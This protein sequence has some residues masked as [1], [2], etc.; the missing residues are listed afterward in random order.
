MKLDEIKK[1]EELYL[2]KSYSFKS[3]Q[4]EIQIIEGFGKEIQWSLLSDKEKLE[5]RK[6]DLMKKYVFKELYSDSIILYEEAIIELVK[7]IM[8][9]LDDVSLIVFD[10]ENMSEEEFILFRLKNMLYIELYSINKRSKLQFSG[11]VLFE[12]IVEP[13]FIY[14]QST[15]F[16]LDYELEK[17]RETYKRVSDLFKKEPYKK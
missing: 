2:L 4:Y 17:L 9:F 5:V 16:Y 15:T 14:V 6:K 7:L 8:K 3:E 11:H 12:E 10:C 13:I 1:I